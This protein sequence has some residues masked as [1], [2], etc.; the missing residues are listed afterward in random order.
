MLAFL[1]E[2]LSMGE[3]HSPS[4]TFTPPPLPSPPLSP[5][6]LYITGRSSSTP[7]GLM[8][9]MRQSVVEGQM[10]SV[11][12]GGVSGYDSVVCPPPSFFC[13]TVVIIT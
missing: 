11:V 4:P 12:C 2:T 13:G 3:A 7:Y 6:T 10:N 9:R 8:D 5:Y 1:Q